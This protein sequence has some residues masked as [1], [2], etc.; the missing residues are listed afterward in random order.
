MLIRSIYRAVLPFVLVCLFAMP[1]AQAQIPDDPTPLPAGAA[2]E[3]LL[4]KLESAEIHARNRQANR[5]IDQALTI[6]RQAND[7]FLKGEWMLA[8][9]RMQQVA[10]MLADMLHYVHTTYFWQQLWF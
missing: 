4:D 10:D 7:A 8:D 9:E 5:A 2:M 6:A 1:D 3:G